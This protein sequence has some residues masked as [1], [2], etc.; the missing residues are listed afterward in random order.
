MKRV[1][2]MVAVAVMALVIGV[3]AEAGLQTI[4]TAT[5]AG[6]DYNLIYD[7]DDHLVWLD[8][9]N[10]Y[11][12]WTSQDGWAAGLNGGGELTYDLNAGLSMDWGTNLWRLPTVTDI[13][14]DGCNWSF[15]G[16][17]DCGYNVDTSTGELAH[18]W[19]DEL[20]NLSYYDTSGNGPQPGWG[21]QNTGDFANLQ[22]HVYWLG[23][24]YAPDANMAWRF[25]TEYGEQSGNSKSIAK[26][27]IAVRSGQLA[28]VPEPVSS[29]LFVI[30]AATMGFRVYRK[31]KI[32]S[33]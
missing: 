30:G 15:S 24:E 8:Y 7:N 28:V 11:T 10:D 33:S 2:T 23:T 27:G 1:V 31:K 12:N 4:G 32:I 29:T 20:G 18:L 16:G 13:G 19:H 26:L 14:N 3:Q 21:L 17:T 22:S 6:S 9:T 25:D 5:Y